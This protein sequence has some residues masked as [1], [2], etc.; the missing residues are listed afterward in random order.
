[1][2]TSSGEVDSSSVCG[3]ESSTVGSELSGS[4]RSHSSDVSHS[5]SVGASSSKKDSS[6]VGGHSS[7][8]SSLSGVECLSETLLVSHEASSLNVLHAGFVSPD[9]HGMVV[10]VS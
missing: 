10:S 2:S 1:M 8:M 7:V 3:S 9:T 4:D 6:T 5:A